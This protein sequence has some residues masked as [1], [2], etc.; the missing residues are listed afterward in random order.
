MNTEFEKM[1]KVDNWLENIS[2]MSTYAKKLWYFF[3]KKPNWQ[4]IHGD[5]KKR[6]WFEKQTNF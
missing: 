2:I 6:P 1:T 3:K 4:K 5:N